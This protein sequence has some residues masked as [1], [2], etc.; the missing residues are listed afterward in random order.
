MLITSI[1]E[2]FHEGG[3]PMFPVLVLGLLMIVAA[4]RYA[5]R[6]D[7][8]NLLIARLMGQVTLVFGFLGSVLGMIHC[9]GAMSEVPNELV[10]KIT[11]LG[12]GESIN[13]IA[14][15]LLLTVVAGLVTAAGALRAAD[16]E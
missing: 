7:A 4:G 6:P 8:R 3:W 12:L 15:A 11:L 9:L 2:K 1:A 10:V 5:V 13:N 16:R 14:L